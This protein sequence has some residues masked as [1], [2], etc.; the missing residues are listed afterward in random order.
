[1]K[2]KPTSWRKSK[3]RVWGKGS[4]YLR[5]TPDIG[6]AIPWFKHS[7]GRKQRIRVAWHHGIQMVQWRGARWVVTRQLFHTKSR[8]NKECFDLPAKKTPKRRAGKGFTN[9]RRF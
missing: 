8:V 5:Y 2:E 9:H 7:T 1:M 3:V 4:F 6:F